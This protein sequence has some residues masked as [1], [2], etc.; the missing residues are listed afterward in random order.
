MEGQ[1]LCKINIQRNEV[2]KKF[3]FII[4]FS[5]LLNWD[6][7]YDYIYYVI[8]ATKCDCFF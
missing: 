2:D 8:E 1:T 7:Y 6:V 3:L 5:F 4:Y